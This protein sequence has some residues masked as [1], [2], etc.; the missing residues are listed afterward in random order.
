MARYLDLF[1]R[2]TPAGLHHC[3]PR[4][5]TNKVGKSHPWY[6]TA[7]DFFGVDSQL[8]SRRNGIQSGVACPTIIKSRFAVVGIP[9]IPGV[10]VR[11]FVALRSPPF[12]LNRPLR[13][14]RFSFTRAS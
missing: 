14:G 13:I 5:P 4:F 8:N 9:S 12:E 11:P 2:K 7:V 10:T 6:S 1:E 3:G